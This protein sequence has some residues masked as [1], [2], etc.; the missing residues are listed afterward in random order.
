MP[1]AG[2]GDSLAKLN[3]RLLTD[4]N[5]R[6]I[7]QAIVCEHVRLGYQYGEP[8]AA[9]IAKQVSETVFKRND[10]AALR[11]VDGILATGMYDATCGRP[12][13]SDSGTVKGDSSR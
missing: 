6:A 11:R 8:K 13:G 2:P 9:A 1:A 7:A 4:S 5:P 3:R 10:E 12:F